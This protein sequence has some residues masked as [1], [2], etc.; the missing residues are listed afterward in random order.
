MVELKPFSLL[1]AETHFKWNNDEELNF[2]DS[3]FPLNLETFDSFI[4]RL[5]LIT[6]EQ[7]TSNRLMEIHVGETGE[8]IGIIDIHNI[9][10]HNLHCSLE[11]TIGDYTYRHKGYGTEALGKALR[12]CFEELNMQKVYASSFDF[13]EKWIRML[14]KTGFKQEG[15]LRRHVQK[16]G[17]YCDKLL[18]GLLKEEFLYAGKPQEAVGVI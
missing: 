3:D 1:N 9:D 15:H 2:Y 7:N 8:L 17:R 11:C 4:N 13:N 6:D 5:K 18:F 10:I 14:T 16:R 12:H